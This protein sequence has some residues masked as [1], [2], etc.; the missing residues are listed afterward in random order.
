LFRSMPPEERQAYLFSQ[1]TSFLLYTTGKDKALSKEKLTQ[2]QTTSPFEYYL[3][4]IWFIVLIVWLFVIYNFLYRGMPQRLETRINL[5]GV[6]KFQQIMARFSV[7]LII[8]LILSSS[9]F[10]IFT[11]QL[12]FD[13]AV[14]D[15]FILL[16][17]INNINL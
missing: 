9:V 15:Y 14:E 16:G 1:F 8:T 13:F 2:H 4:A 6:T 17:L 10:F 7:T 5:Y 11:Y 12:I 3:V